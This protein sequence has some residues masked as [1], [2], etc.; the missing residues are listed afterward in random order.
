[1]TPLAPVEVIGTRKTLAITAIVDTGFDGDLCLPIRIAVQL[2][3]ELVGEQIVELA[4]GTRKRELAFDGS[5]RFF[6]DAQAVRIMLTS[7][8]DAPIG[9]RLLNH[10]RAAIEF[11]GGRLKLRQRPESGGRK[12]SQP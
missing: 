7:S 2:G 1:M 5:V 9:T 6:N 11:P 4:D 12:K 3:L 10:Y 8:E